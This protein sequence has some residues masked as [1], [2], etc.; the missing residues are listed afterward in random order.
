MK[1]LKTKEKIGNGTLL[2]TDGPL[3]YLEFECL[4]HYGDILTHCMST[5]IGGVSEGECRS[6]NFGFRRND[7]RENVLRN[8]QLLCE[9]VGF[10]PESLVLSDQVHGKTI[11]W[12]DGNDF[13]KGYCRESD[14]TGVDGLMTQTGGLTM[15]TFYADCIP[16][17][18]FEP[19]IKAAALVHSGW[20]GTLQGIA[21]EAVRQMAGIPGFRSDRLVVVLG[22]SIA[23]CCFEV[24]RDVYELFS[25]R[26]GETEFFKPQQDGKWKIDLQGLIKAELAQNGL[27]EE[28]I[29]ISGIC[30]KCRKDLFFSYRGD[31]GKTGSLAAFMQLK[32]NRGGS[33]T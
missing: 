18:L 28:N 8:F 25:A 3:K 11:R 6:L 21:V 9:S 14:L 27:C 30:T 33:M 12:V 13:G 5:R 29:H 20:K 31:G 4:N 7:T 26:Y 2:V 23:R 16:V 1:P 24:R 17:F 22:P 32:Q 10:E 15:V 19:G